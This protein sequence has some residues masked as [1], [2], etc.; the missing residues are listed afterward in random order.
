MVCYQCLPNV[1]VRNAS[2][3][4]VSNRYVHTC[5]FSNIPRRQTVASNM[6][7]ICHTNVFT[8]QTKLNVIITYTLCKIQKNNPFPSDRCCWRDVPRRHCSVVHS[9]VFRNCEIVV[10]SVPYNWSALILFMGLQNKNDL[11]FVFFFL[12]YYRLLTQF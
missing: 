8:I 4:F 9:F 6:R 12:C 7:S 5:E 10:N 2:G 11:G 1:S 3:V